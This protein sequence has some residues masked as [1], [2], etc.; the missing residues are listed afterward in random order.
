M[1]RYLCACTHGC[2]QAREHPHKSWETERSSVS[3]YR[4]VDQDLE[5]TA[6][7]RGDEWAS[8]ASL[9]HAATLFYT[10]L[11]FRETQ[12]RE[13]GAVSLLEWR[14]GST[15]QMFKSILEKNLLMPRRSGIWSEMEAALSSLPVIKE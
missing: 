7:R 4:C 9:K 10:V 14:L 5:S 11:E 12:S 15:L 8:L 2:V 13:H 3:Q 6:K 1:C